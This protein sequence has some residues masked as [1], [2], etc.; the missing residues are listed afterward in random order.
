MEGCRI[1][2]E[3]LSGASRLRRR[4]SNAPEFFTGFEKLNAHVVAAFPWTVAAPHHSEG[5]DR[6]FLA[7][8]DLQRASLFERVRNTQQGAIAVDH[9]GLGRVVDR[10]PVLARAVDLH[11][12]ADQDAFSASTL[13]RLGLCTE[14]H[15][16]AILPV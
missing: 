9:Y 7:L 10:L 5:F 11:R 8:N 1:K 3:K 14:V 4:K 16:P 2:R 15:E 12:H 6:F 13:A